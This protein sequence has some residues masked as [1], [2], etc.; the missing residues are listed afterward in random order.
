MKIF[1]IFLFLSQLIPGIR[2]QESPVSADVEVDWEQSVIRVQTSVSF[3]SIKTTLPSARSEAVEM[4]EDRLPGFIRQ[5][6]YSLPYDSQTLIE[7]N[8]LE[9]SGKLNSLDSYATAA[10]TH[11]YHV[12]PSLTYIKGE[13][14]LPFFPGLYSIFV[15]HENAY[16]PEK[17]L[18]FVPTTSFSGIVI[19]AKGKL[20]VHGEDGDDVLSPSL[21]PK[22]FDE[23]MDLVAEYRMMLP[24]SLKRWGPVQYTSSERL[25]SFRERIGDTPLITM[26][27]AVFGKHR[28]DLIIS[29]EAAEKIL[30]SDTNIELLQEGRILIICDIR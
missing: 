26:A 7:D 29:S 12:N 9:N 6:L 20:K 24:E 25:S 27:Y 19:Y 22:I 10:N 30:Y 1:Y 15:D 8:V 3:S 28:T 21:F 5:A 17:I 13:F 11:S 23:N 4:I 14:L 16:K 2:A 18:S